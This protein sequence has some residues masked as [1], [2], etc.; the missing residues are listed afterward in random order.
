MERILVVD[1]ATGITTVIKEMLTRHN[2]TVITARNGRDALEK[3]VLGPVDLVI[4]DMIMPDID[5]MH[6][7][8]EIHRQLPK[9]RIIAMS[10]GGERFGS[11]LYLKEARRLGAAHL[12]TKP[13]LMNEL[14]DLVQRTLAEGP[15]QEVNV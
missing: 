2:Y 13:F 8:P 3:L 6:L 7:I 15:D 10:G 14:L 1:D 5:G 9:V 12:L 4:T 11:D